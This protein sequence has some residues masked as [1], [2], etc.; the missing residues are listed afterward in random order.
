MYSKYSW[1]YNTPKATKD[2]GSCITVLLSILA[3]L[4]F[5]VFEEA[6]LVLKR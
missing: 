5:H 2:L 1:V 6:V 3:S 4:H